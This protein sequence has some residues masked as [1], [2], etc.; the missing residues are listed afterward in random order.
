MEHVRTFLIQVALTK[1]LWVEAA[2]FVI[3]LKNHSIT[4]VLGNATLHEC[5]TG[6]KLN[7]A[8]LLEWGQ[9]MW[10]YAGKSS[11]LSKHTMLTHWI[12]Y[13]KGSPHTHWIYWSE[14][15]SVTTE[16]NV[17]FTA[18]FSTVYTLPGPV[19]DPLPTSPAQSTPPL[20]AQHLAPQTP[21]A[22]PPEQMQPPPPAMS[23]S[24]EEVEVEGKLNEDK[25]PS[26]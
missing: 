1:L 2:H 9:C 8:G 16:R 26:V 18:D 25:P 14:T 22:S 24:E 4:H 5:L 20:Q 15:R 12:G 10:V 19:H 6:C 23:S 13:D 17:W 21:P 3:W 11:K 7:L